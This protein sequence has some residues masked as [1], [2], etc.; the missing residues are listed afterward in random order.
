MCNQQFKLVR[1]LERACR[2]VI[3][4][5]CD[6]KFLVTCKKN[7]LTLMFAKPRLSVK[8]NNKVRWKITQ[9]IIEAELNNKYKKLKLLKQQEKEN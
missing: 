5:T 8:V 2:K 3:K 1:S 4:L 9:T 7:K 6:I